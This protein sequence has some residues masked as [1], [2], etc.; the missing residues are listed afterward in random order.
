MT[1]TPDEHGSTLPPEDSEDVMDGDEVTSTDDL[2][3]EERLRDSSAE[4]STG[5]S[6][7]AGNLSDGAVD[8]IGDD[9]AAGDGMATAMNGPGI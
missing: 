3:A 4:T 5:G 6:L 9:G 8:G 7:G 1:L 2:D